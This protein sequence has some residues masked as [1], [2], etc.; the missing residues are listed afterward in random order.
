MGVSLRWRISIRAVYAARAS[1]APAGAK[2]WLRVS[3]CHRSTA[4]ATTA[5]SSASASSAAPRSPRSTSPAAWPSDLAT[6]VGRSFHQGPA[7]VLRTGV[8]D[9]AVL[10]AARLVDAR[11]QAGVAR[12]L[13]R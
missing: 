8:R 10:G 5:T 2:V 12:E 4:T 9:A 7:Q 6:G 11:A 13:L 1:M 3:M